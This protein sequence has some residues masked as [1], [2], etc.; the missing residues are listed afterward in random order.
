MEG[1]HLKLLSII[2]IQK[3]DARLSPAEKMAD[4]L[5]LRLVPAAHTS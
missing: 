4:R 1:H 2:E 5:F 3:K